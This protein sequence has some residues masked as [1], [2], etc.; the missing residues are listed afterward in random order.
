MED[1][2]FITLTNDGYIDYTLNLLKSLEIYNLEKKLKCYCI[3]DECYNKLIK[4]GYTAILLDD[5][6]NTNFCKFRQNNWG[7]IVSKKFDI[8]TENLKTHKYVLITDG[9]IVFTN[10]NAISYLLENVE[11]NDMIIQSS[12]NKR[13]CSGFFMLRSNEKTIKLFHP[14]NVEKQ[15]TEKKWGDQKYINKIKHKL[16]YKRLPELLYP[17][18]KI[19]YENFKDINPY[20]IHFNFVIGENKRIR[21]KKYNHL[22]LNNYKMTLET[23]QKTKKPVNSLLVQGSTT[24]G[25]DGWQDW[26]I[27]YNW[28]YMK[29]SNNEK[30]EIQIGKHNNLLTVGIKVGTDIARRKKSSVN[31][32]KILK[33]LEKTGFNNKTF[34]PIEYFRKLSSY[35][36][37]VSPEGNGIDCH[38]HYEALMSG[39]IPI[40]E[41]NEKTEKKYEGLPILYTK[42]YSEI[43]EEYLIKK[44]N[45]MLKKEY[46]FDKMCLYYYTKEQQ[47]EIKICCDH[48]CKKHNFESHY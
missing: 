30:G 3:G 13:L 25:R 43:N 46:N 4:L 1:L 16:K 11:D 41:Y 15:K 45:E 29:L 44:Y 40:C 39:S 19:Y 35:K 23:W 31:R 38:K 18:G 22:Y 37:V 9:D 36:F 5:K 20:I 28:K 14:I 34:R 21:M 32:L 42:D 10:K 48:W 12:R 33:T 6:I 26:I 24:D 2:A 47:E 7:D 8:I 17:N 27:G